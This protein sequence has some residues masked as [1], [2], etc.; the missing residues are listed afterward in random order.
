MRVYAMGRP[1]RPQMEALQLRAAASGIAGSIRRKAQIISERVARLAM[2]DTEHDAEAA[3]AAALARA[4]A[5]DAPSPLFRLATEP[6]INVAESIHN[7]RAR[8]F[9]DRGYRQLDREGWARETR[10]I[11]AVVAR[12][13]AE[14][15]RRMMRRKRA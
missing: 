2:E 4:Q 5:L 1:S 3:F 7:E 15:Y 12:R 9:A 11:E 13:L 10:E 14:R 8:R 6:E